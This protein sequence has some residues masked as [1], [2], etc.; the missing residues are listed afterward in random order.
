MVYT[1]TLW[2]ALIQVRRFRA[3]LNCFL[4][5]FLAEIVDLFP[6]ADV[7]DNGA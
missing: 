5:H 7:V 2:Y 4:V 6:G 1:V 3:F